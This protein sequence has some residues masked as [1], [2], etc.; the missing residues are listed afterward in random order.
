MHSPNPMEK[1]D[2]LEPWLPDEDTLFPELARA[3]LE[4]ELLKSQ[5]VVFLAAQERVNS[6]DYGIV[7]A[8]IKLWERRSVPIAANS[9]ANKLQR[10]RTP[11]IQV[12]TH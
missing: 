8:Q 6:P 10:N 5:A 12:V 3:E 1:C 4:E 2:C 7:I 9:R 11:K